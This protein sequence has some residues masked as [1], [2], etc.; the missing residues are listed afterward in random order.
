MSKDHKGEGMEVSNWIGIAGGLALFIYG[1]RI[2]GDGIERMAGSKLK[3]ILEKLTRNRFLGLLVGV[4]I[5][6]IIQSSNATAAMT[7]GFVNAGLMDLGNAVG[8]I[9]GAN[10]G[11]TITGQLIAFKIDS[12]AP[13]IT[14]V[15]VAL[16]MFS[17]KNR[18]VSF[19][20]TIVGLGVLFMGMRLMTDNMQPLAREQWF[21]DLMA[22]MENPFLGIL[23]G[24]LFTL[25][26]QSVSASVGI[27]QAM[28]GAGVIG[29]HQAIYIICGQNIGCTVAAV[30]AAVGGTKQAKRTALFHVLFNV[31]ASLI[32][33][34]LCSLLPCVD[35]IISLHPDDPVRQIADANTLLKVA[36]TIIQ[37]PCA[38]LIIKLTKLLIPGEDEL[39]GQRLL[40]IN[41]VD[42]GMSSIAIA[43]VQAEVKRMY[44]LAQSN[45]E[46]AWKAMFHPEKGDIERLRRDEETINYLNRE[47]TVALVE[48]N[49]S[50]LGAGDARLIDQM[51]HVIVDFE[52]IGDHADNI[53][54]YIE[55]CREADL[56]FSEIAAS[57]LT[58]LFEKVCGI[59]RD[60]YATMTS[61][62]DHPLK[63]IEDR[64]EEVDV[65]V[66]RLENEHIKRLEQG[67]C[68]A[69]VGMMYV[70]ILTDLERVSDHALNIAQAAIRDEHHKKEL[71]AH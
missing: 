35:W 18:M 49:S 62:I 46:G 25:I 41:K 30:T 9:M 39:S 68:K 1:I 57:E 61:P 2:M 60:A 24:T 59:V 10:I 29:L 70:E 51:H 27:L 7:V 14:F 23:A 6:A 36:A 34:A 53:A 47:I 13:I 33:V 5:T 28:A 11:T 65:T 16:L 56:N 21:I 54:G 20:Q 31:F 69:E 38:S 48:I 55:H 58:Q 42:F 43:Q 17:K 71:P 50:G 67:L 63:D 15:G 19:A 3:S 4:G 8:V 37:F 45:L 52:R 40:H 66:E 26:F 12:I 22:G 64:E 44:E 32:C